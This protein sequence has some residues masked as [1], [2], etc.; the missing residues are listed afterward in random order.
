MSI[1]A[2]YKSSKYGEELTTYEGQG[3][4]AIDTLN[5]LRSRLP[6]L[7]TTIGNDADLSADAKT[8]AVAEVD[9]AIAALVQQIKDF[10]NGL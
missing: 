3:Q 6:A 4:R 7:K 2:D 5:T 9:A 1:R 10:A 8:A